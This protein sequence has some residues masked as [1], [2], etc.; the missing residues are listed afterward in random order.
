MNEEQLRAQIT[1]ALHDAKD[2]RVR[3]DLG[4]RE[5]ALVQAR[6]GAARLGDAALLGVACW[7]LAKLRYDAGEAEGLID[8]LAPLVQLKVEERGV[9]GVK[10]QVG[11]FDHYEAGLR[12]LPAIARRHWD[13]LGYAHPIV[14]Q[15]W[16]AYS[17]AQRQR[18]DPFLAAWGDVQR[19]WQLACTG[20]L[21]ELVALT[22]TYA[23]LTPARFGPGPHRHPRADDAASSVHWVQVDL[24]RTLLCAATWLHDEPRAW[25]A[26]ELLEDA[27]ED[28]GLERSVDFW[29]LDA[30]L[31]SAG[32][33]A[34]TEIV[35]RYLP[36]YEAVLA[37]EP[38]E[39]APAHRARGQAWL[40]FLRRQRATAQEH[41]SLA[42][43]LTRHHRA[44]PEWVVETALLGAIAAP[45][46]R[47]VALRAVAREEALRTGVVMCDLAGI[48]AC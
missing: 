27:A 25:E 39:L 43:D 15:L 32:R 37:S 35:E 19:S 7:R 47:A 3:Q 40:A 2:A 11:P 9:W 33:F 48:R 28:A 21:D 46:E 45:P 41:A 23:R 30:V 14:E 10:Q 8:A 1:A 38:I 42:L 13:H 5:A 17:E 12:A 26:M 6:E 31:R 24:A 44:G 22:L 16:L 36:A 29:F 20:R 34:R 18:Q 4:A